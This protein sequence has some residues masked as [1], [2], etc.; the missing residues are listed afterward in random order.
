MYIIDK[1]E[2]KRRVNITLK[3]RN[4]SNSFLKR[5]LINLIN[6]FILKNIN[7]NILI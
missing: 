1:A 5:L 4:L 7:V 2:K 3:A 6:I